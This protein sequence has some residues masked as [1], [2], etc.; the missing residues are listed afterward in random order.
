MTKGRAAALTYFAHTVPGIDDLAATELTRLGATVRGTLTGFDRRD[1]IVLFGAAE[2]DVGVRAGLIEDVFVVMLDVPTPA[3]SAA[4]ALAAQLDRP[5]L[6]R[7][8]AVHNAIRPK[9]GR[10]TYGVVARVAG[11][12]A[13]HR[14]DLE[15]V[16]GRAIGK[17]LP[18][19][20]LATERAALEVWVQV[21]GE[22][23]LVGARISVDEM[24]QRKYKTAHLPASLKPTAARALV[25]MSEPLADDVVL[26]P[27]CGAGTILRERADA[28]RAALM[29]GGDLDADAVEAARTNAR[30]SA[31]VLR[32]DATRLPLP[33]R[34]IDVVISNP[35]YG[36]RHGEIRGLDRLY[37]RSTREMARVLRPDGRC[38]LLTGEPDLLFRA[39]SPA[40]RIVTKRRML[41]RGLPV[42]AFAMVRA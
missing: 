9:V 38:V 26:D 12:Q 32:W 18:R 5:T 29:L 36:R 31:R 19:W 3:R 25:A 33:D 40:L 23:T 6:E 28:G 34:S 14:E 37:A 24:A 39:L 15:A 21:I 41:L 27:M 42:T 7:A 11:R 20:T 22:R 30:R 17:L 1:S 35:P 2:P 10:K 16:F 13:F 4:K 8:L